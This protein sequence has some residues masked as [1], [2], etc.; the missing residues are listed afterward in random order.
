MKVSHGG[1]WGMS[2]HILVSALPVSAKVSDSEFPKGRRQLQ[3]GALTY[4]LA[5]FFA[6]NCMK[7][8]S[9]WMPIDSLLLSRKSFNIH[10]THSICI[11][12]HQ[13]S[14]FSLE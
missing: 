8:K 7:T 2:S 3:K 1:M 14:F 11:R 6:E 12:K 13:D 5:Y 4:Y 10:T 9:K